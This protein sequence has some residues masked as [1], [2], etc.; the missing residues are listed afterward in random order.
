M[1]FTA[2][3]FLCAD[4]S[5]GELTPNS[6]YEIKTQYYE[7]VFLALCGFDCIDICRLW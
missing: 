4:Y 3:N 6:N 1:T 2:P 5:N 7:K